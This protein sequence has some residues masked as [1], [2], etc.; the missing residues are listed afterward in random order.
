MAMAGVDIKIGIAGPPDHRHRIRHHRAK[1][2]PQLSLLLIEGTGEEFVRGGQQN[3]EIACT[4]SP[5]ETRKLRRRGKPQ[6]AAEP[7]IGDESIL[8]D[9]AHARPLAFVSER[10][11][12]RVALDRIDRKIDADLAA[13]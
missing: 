4:E 13:E 1:P 7:R 6:A 10:K 11:S 9:A 3:T 12:R 8:I 5:V 2:R